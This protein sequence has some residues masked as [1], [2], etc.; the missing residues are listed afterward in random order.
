MSEEKDPNEQSQE[1]DPHGLNLKT[2]G[3]KAD[4]GK[5]AFL[6]GC[7]QYFPRALLEVARVSQR[8]AEK[9]SWSGWEQVPDGIRR[10]GDALGRHLAYESME[11]EYD[12]ETGL[13]HAAQIA[14]NSLA[15]LELILREKEISE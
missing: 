4:S 8:G 15:R 10:Y 12:K 11:G 13:L 3:A 7:I 1:R 2:P 6:R 14:W 5:V 9:Y